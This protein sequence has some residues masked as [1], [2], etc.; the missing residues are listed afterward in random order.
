MGGHVLLN[1]FCHYLL[2]LFSF[3]P[4]ELVIALGGFSVFAGTFFAGGSVRAYF[5]GW[6]F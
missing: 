4:G 2:M 5:L 6:Q 3:F 1:L